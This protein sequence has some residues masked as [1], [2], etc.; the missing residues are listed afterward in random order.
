VTAVANVAA[1]ASALALASFMG[2]GTAGAVAAWAAGQIA[3]SAA[4]LALAARRLPVVPRWRGRVTAELAGSGWALA[5]NAFLVTV[6]LRVGQLIVLRVEG[7]AA[8]GYLTAGSRLAE[9]FALVPESVMLMLLPILAGY[10]ATD[11]A[12]QR[13]VSVRAVRCLA[14]LALPVIIALSIAA[15]A[16]LALLYGPAYAVGAPALQVS[17]WLALL[18]AS[19]TVFTNLLIAR[20]FERLLLALNAIASLLTLALSVLLVPRLGFVGA[21]VATLTASVVSQAVLLALPSTRADVAACLRP[22]ARPVLVAAGLVLA[23]IAVTGPRPVVAA[24][25]AG[26]FVVVMIATRTI[27]ADDWRLFRRVLLAGR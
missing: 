4:A 15:P 8:V 20:A 12:A 3:A 9:A 23:G 1:F 7:A 22:L 16:L 17:A 21:A 27:D 24:A 25:A 14:L 13:R 26:V 11:W 2:A 6:T 18:A 19:G 5:S 10:D